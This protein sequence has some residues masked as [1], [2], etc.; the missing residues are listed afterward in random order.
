MAL[1]DLLTPLEVRGLLDR[2]EGV[3]ALISRFVYGTGM[4]LLEGLRLR[5]KDVDF[6]RRMIVIREGKGARDRVTMLPES[7]VEPLRAHQVR[8]RALH[9]RDLV[10]GFGAVFLPNMLEGKS[11][12][13]ATA[14]GRQ[15]V[16]PS[17]VRF[18]GPR[19]GKTR[20]RHIYPEG[21]QQAVR[22]AARAM[23]LAK[24]VTPHVL[25]HGFSIHLLPGGH[26]IRT[27]QELLGHRDV[28]TTMIYTH[29]LNRGG[30]GVMSPLDQIFPTRFGIRVG[31][32]SM[33]QIF[34]S[35]C[36]IQALGVS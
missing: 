2:V 26:D 17:G 27:V 36:N 22:E 21:A 33:R 8:A 6:A 3:S 15:W 29:G 12:R 18:M 1:P 28:R 31:K 34:G 9:E 5:A 20:R 14:W 13:S 11:P 25:R 32:I 30:G 4:R 23:D 19:S 7:L 16:F 24:P 10:E 35:T